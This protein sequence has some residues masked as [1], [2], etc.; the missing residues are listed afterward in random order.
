MRLGEWLVHE[1]QISVEE[2][3]KALENQIV[4]GGRLGTNLVENKSITLDGLSK[5]LAKKSQ[6]PE[7][8]S[9]HFDARHS[10]V[11]IQLNVSLAESLKVIPLYQSGNFTNSVIVAG[12]DPMASTTHDVLSKI[13]GKHISYGIAPELRILYWLEQIFGVQRANRFKRI[14]TDS[15]NNGSQP[16]NRKYV[17]AITGSDET[18]L[19]KKVARIAVKRV[20]V[21]VKNDT[22][23]MVDPKDLNAINRAIKRELPRE[24]IADLTMLA[25]RQN[26]EN[27]MSSGLLLLCREHILESWRGFTL[28]NDDNY[29]LIEDIAISLKEDSLFKTSLES[30]RDYTKGPIANPSPIDKM[31]QKAISSASNADISLFPLALQERNL[32]FL[33]VEGKT[34][35]SD[36]EFIHLKELANSICM[37]FKRLINAAKR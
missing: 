27:K 36:Q 30:R 5:A 8:T 26:F 37:G 13:Y 18:S 7:V 15:S 10:L 20:T 31:F 35:F 24:D 34:R 11:S 32:G 3:T 9:S 23:K 33:V 22:R 17:R 16:T 21:S 1:G 28:R 25:L 19:N 6:L 12:M 2:L 4:N 29:S 14:D